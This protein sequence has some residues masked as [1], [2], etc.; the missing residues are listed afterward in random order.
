[1]R[2][3]IIE[4]FDLP[5]PYNLWHSVRFQRMG[6]LD[7][8]VILD[9]N[10]YAFASNLPSGPATALVE[11]Q[12][13]RLRCR[14]WGPGSHALLEKIPAQLGLTMPLLAEGIETL[15]KPLRLVRAQGLRR[16]ARGPE[17][18]IE[19]LVPIVLQQLVTWREAAK[20]WRAL[21]QTHGEPAPGPLKLIL[22]P[23]L[24]SL[25]SLT[26][27]D[28]RQLEIASKRG[29]TI[30]AIC[31]W[32][33]RHSNPTQPEQLLKLKGIGPWTSALYR[34]LE[35]G[36][37]DVVPV[38]DYHLPTTVS[39]ALTQN[40]RATDETMLRLLEPFRGYR[41]EIIRLIMGANI[42]APRRSARMP[43]RKLQSLR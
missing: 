7:P 24:A 17:R 42:A 5:K 25:R 12:D 21:L 37:A 35:L 19:T 32:L 22:P 6:K 15:P 43:Q 11:L 38:G 31:E 4:E 2:P 14:L 20:S 1:M 28:L 33:A 40:R 27:G 3:E 41:F 8:R 18:V 39:W 26:L 30:L 23:T 16:T 36:D 29:R 10:H 13:T 34:G 9:R